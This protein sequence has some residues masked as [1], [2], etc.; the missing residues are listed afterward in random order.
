MSRTHLRRPFEI[1]SLLVGLGVVAPATHAAE[2]VAATSV[3]EL[4][5]LAAPKTDPAEQLVA[6]AIAAAL[7]NDFKAWLETMHPKERATPQQQ[8]QLEK[9]TDQFV[10]ELR[11]QAAVVVKL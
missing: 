2:P 1:V 10:Q 11:T 3:N 5:T 6:K 7:A 8:S 4:A 9:Y